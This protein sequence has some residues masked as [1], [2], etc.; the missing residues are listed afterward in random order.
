[1]DGHHVTS[2]THDLPSRVIFRVVE[3]YAFANLLK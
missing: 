3:L 2:K 1:L